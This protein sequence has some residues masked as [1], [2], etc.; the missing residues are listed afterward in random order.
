MR[1]RTDLKSLAVLGVLVGIVAG[2]VFSYVQDSLAS[3]NSSGTYSLPSGNPVVSGTAISSTVHNNTMSDVASELTNSL[4]RNGRGAMLAPLQLASGT[5]SAPGLTFSGDADTGFYR[6]GAND[7]ALSAGGTKA[8]EWQSTGATFPL[9]ATT[10]AGITATQSTMNG[11][12][13]TATG[14]GTGSG[15]TATG[16]SN[17]GDGVRGTGGAG[18]GLGVHG[19]G[20]STNGTGVQGEASGSGNGV[21][22]STTG[23]GNGVRAQSAGAGAALY[24]TNSGGGNA[25]EV[26]T[27]NAKFSAG[28]PSSSTAFTNTLTQTNFAKV[29]ATVTSSGSATLT[30]SDGFNVTSASAST[31]VVTITFA[32]AFANTNYSV[33]LTGDGG[34][35]LACKPGTKTTTTLVV[36]CLDVGAGSVP[37]SAINFQTASAGTAVIHLLAFGAQ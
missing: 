5:V 3:R 20:G 8:Q 21:F 27:G 16:G 23:S 32:S 26:S 6:I 36:S 13:V 15:V 25:I 7:V 35:Y 10:Q 29:W 12:A 28:N 4:D 1:S 37:F 18:S 34:S 14:N 19:V 9:V 24:A 11:S 33:Q 30:I 22:G 31:S 17:A 2:Q